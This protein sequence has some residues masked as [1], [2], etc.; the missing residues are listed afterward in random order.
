MEAQ[1]F[2]GVNI[3]PAV[4]VDLPSKPSPLTRQDTGSTRSNSKYTPLPPGFYTLPIHGNCPRC[5]HHHSSAEVRVRLSEDITRVS[6]VNCQKCG[7]RW[8]AFGGQN[9]TCIS[10]LSTQ[11]TDPDERELRYRLTIINLVRSAASFGSVAFPSAALSSGPESSAAGLSRRSSVPNT[12]FQEFSD[13]PA[14][15]PVAAR[16]GPAQ[17]KP[18]TAT[19][20][21]HDASLS[22]ITPDT[23]AGKAKQKKKNLLDH[24]KT[25]FKDRLFSFRMSH[26]KKT[27]RSTGEPPIGKK[28][29]EKL[30]EP[31]DTPMPHFQE[32]SGSS[33]SYVQMNPLKEDLRALVGDDSPV[34]SG[35]PRV[36]FDKEAL[37]KMDKDERI[38]WARKQIT[39][40]KCRCPKDCRCQRA[41]PSP[42]SSNIGEVGTPIEGPPS[43]LELSFEEPISRRRSTDTYFAGIGSH[44][45]SSA[46]FDRTRH[47]SLTST[48][49]S[50]ALTVVGSDTMTMISESPPTPMLAP[51]PQQMQAS[52][53]S[54]PQSFAVPSRTMSPLRHSRTPEDLDIG[55]STDSF[56]TDEAVRVLS[57]NTP[58]PH[59]QQAFSLPPSSISA[60]R[61][62]STSSSHP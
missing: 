49:L 62:S 34:E 36:A 54:R 30:I 6:K 40:F 37:E 31:V 28:G 60:H 18:P 5:H 17:D 48:R 32:V 45:Q 55:V 11:T 22:E 41:G 21:P 8:L 25:K 9:A 58:P 23:A 14:S 19:S 24:L 20:R 53:S 3:G 38:A 39:D 59:R 43:S 46:S 1:E 56:A 61:N 10:L 2:P 50:Q 35:S 42:V 16:H 4:G 44:L 7:E 29:K 57:E 27:P 13:T 26:L 15:W 12:N 47:F 33:P 51:Q 52:T